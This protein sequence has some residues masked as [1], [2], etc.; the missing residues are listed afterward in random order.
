MSRRTHTLAVAAPVVRP[1]AVA[2][3][4]ALGKPR[5]VAMVLV[6]T[7]VGFYLG[8]H[9]ASAPLTF[10]WTLLGTGLAAAGTLALNQYLERDLDA[11][12]ERTKSRPLPSGRLQPLDALLFGAAVTAA[13]L[14][15]LTLKVNALSGLVTAT[16]VVTYLFCYT[17]MKVRTPLC[18]IVGAIPGALPPVT[19]WVA[20]TGEFAPGAW[21][22]FAIMFLWQLPHSLAIAKLYADD[23]ARAGF[24]LLPIVERHSGMTERQIVGQ[25]AALLAV[26]L[27]PTLVGVAGPVYFAVALLLGIAFLLCGISLALS[28]STVAAR[29]LLIASLLY[30][31][32]LL[33]C[34]AADRV[35][36]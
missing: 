34:M 6:T 7:A 12:M 25:C 35:G 10:V 36:G 20:A 28:S 26:G 23:Y 27:M 18:S 31:P 16:I 24:R 15:L 9:G 19:G 33:A 3:F 22:L 1:R 13:G 2:D 17:P 32:L 14:I 5:V 30:L 21:V 8:A 29:R 11:H 4:I